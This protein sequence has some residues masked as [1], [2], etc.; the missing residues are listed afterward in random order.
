M[1]L[2]GST[3]LAARAIARLDEFMGSALSGRTILVIGLGPV[4]SEV[5]QLAKQSGMWVLAVNRIGQTDLP[6][7]DEI[8]TSRFLGDLLPVAHAVVLALP[9]TDNTRQMI[10]AATITRMRLDAFVVN[11]GSVEV[12]DTVALDEAVAGGRI[13]GAALDLT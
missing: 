11:V 10:N 9:L 4:G 6:Y 3:Q 2:E 12:I 5:A 8:R 7:I 1:S 13:A